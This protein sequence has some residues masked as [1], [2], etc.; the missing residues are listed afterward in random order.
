[1]IER[2]VAILTLEKR[3]LSGLNDQFSFPPDKAAITIS[4]GTFA[5]HDMQTRPYGEHRKKEPRS[6]NSF[7][8][9]IGVSSNLDSGKPVGFM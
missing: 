8:Y 6:W 9:Y 7:P 1:M 4:S 2:P 3:I 5:G